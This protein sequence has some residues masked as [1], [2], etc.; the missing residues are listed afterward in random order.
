MNKKLLCVGMAVAMLFSLAACS[1]Q[2]GETADTAVSVSKSASTGSESDSEV[3]TIQVGELYSVTDE[4]EEDID[5]EWSYKSADKD[6]AIVRSGKYIVGIGEGSTDVTITEDGTTT[7]YC[8]EVVPRQDES[9]L[10]KVANIKDKSVYIGS[11]YN[12]LKAKEYI[13]SN[14][15][16]IGNSIFSAS[17]VSAQ[18]D[19][20][21]NYAYMDTDTTNKTISVSES[22]IEEYSKKFAEKLEGKLK[23]NVAKVV[24]GEAEGKFSEAKNNS[25]NKKT[26]FNTVMFTAQRVSYF[27]VNNEKLY[28]LAKK[29][30]AA[31]SDLTNPNILPAE[32][33]EK[34]GTHIITGAILGGRLELNYS[35]SSSDENK[36]QEELLAIAG[37]ITANISAVSGEVNA[38]FDKSEIENA[39]NSNCQIKTT[40]NTYGGAS[41]KDTLVTSL[42]TYN[43][44]FSNWYGSLE[45]SNYALIDVTNN[46]LIPIWQL[47]KNPQDPSENAERM[48][49]L[50]TYY[51]ENIGV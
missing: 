8:V 42:E 29:N 34:Y 44:A 13:T 1:N 31:W 10:R 51:N 30:T 35:L 36:S 12:A 40:V 33:F 26:V 16:I 22:S 24:S 4:A 38:A 46:G 49:E 45:E 11:G 9:R 19:N 47:L 15:L 25:E 20:D 48:L 6:V 14:D 50:Q 37:K 32:I 7:E 17:D 39:Q 2:E 27:V 41:T 21:M 3:L 18:I 23:V 43:T 5:V 28:E